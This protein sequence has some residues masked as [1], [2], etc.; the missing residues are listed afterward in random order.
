M[1][2]QDKDFMKRNFEEF[3][4]EVQCAI[5]ENNKMY[6]KQITDL[7]T[8]LLTRQSDFQRVEKQNL[9]L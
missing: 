3:E 8:D 9:L 2:K 1:F 4:D 5:E 7:K 6:R